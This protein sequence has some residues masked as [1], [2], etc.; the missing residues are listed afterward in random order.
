MKRE[1]KPIFVERRPNNQ[2]F[3]IRFALVSAKPL[4]PAE[5]QRMRELAPDPSRSSCDRSVFTL[6]AKKSVA[7][8]PITVQQTLPRT[9]FRCD[10]RMAGTRGVCAPHWRE[11]R[12]SNDSTLKNWR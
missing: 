2:E 10:S 11:G 1:R 9:E 8:Y 7:M 4:L 12:S 5:N 6:R 3:N